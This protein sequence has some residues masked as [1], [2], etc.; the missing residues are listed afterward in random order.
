M[1]NI[2]VSAVILLVTIL[3]LVTPLFPVP[4]SQ[5][6]V[7]TNSYTTQFQVPTTTYEVQTIYSL[8]RPVTLMGLTGPPATAIFVSTEFKLQSNFMYEA[9]VTCQPCETGKGSIAF[10]FLFPQGNNT[11]L[12]YPLRYDVPGQGHG[13]LTVSRSGVYGIVMYC[14][15]SCTIST[16]SIIVSVPYSFQLTE[17]ATTYNTVTMTEHSQT[18]VPIYTILGVLASGAI[19]VLLALLVVLSILFDRRMISAS[20]KRRVAVL[21]VFSSASS[22]RIDW[23]IACTLWFVDKK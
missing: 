14:I 7:Q 20:T 17:T 18:T 15:N 8:P 11:L 21:H 16:L 5:E 10:L 19:L 23:V 6:V 13:N 22:T 1:K 4:V 12:E 3:V 9:E 2:L